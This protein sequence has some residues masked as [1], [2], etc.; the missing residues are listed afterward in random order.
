MKTRPHKI[1]LAALMLAIA[2]MASTIFPNIQSGAESPVI[3]GRGDYS[4]ENTSAVATS[5]VYEARR[6]MPLSFE[7]NRGQA[8]ADVKFVGRGDGFALLLKPNEAVLSL[9]KRKQALAGGAAAA[10]SND[11]LLASHLLSMKL[12]GANSTPLISGEEQQ[13]VR[14]NYFI[15][16]DPAKWLRDVETF[17]RVS[18]TGLYRGVDLTFY[19]N[20][21][22]LE[23]DFTVAPGADPREIRL[24]FEGADDVELNSEG[25]LILHTTAGAVRHDRPVAYQ[26][27]NGSRLE[28]PAE[29]RRL[30][31]GAIGF[32]V[33]SYDPARPLVIDPVLVY[34]TYL[35]GNAADSCRGIVVDSAGNSFLVGDSFSSN[36]LR[37]ASA[38]NSDVFIG[39]LSQSGLLL[40]YTFFG[41]SKNDSAT[42]LAVDSSGNLY[43]CG[44][45]E[46]PDFPIFNSVGSTLLG[47]SDAFVVKLTPPGDQ[48]FYSSLVGGSGSESGV[49]IAGDSAGNAYITGRTTSLDFPIV[50]PIQPVYGGGDSDAFVAKLAPDGKVL[51]YSSF[52]GGAGTEDLIAKT[53]IAVDS[54][55]NAYVVGDTQSSN[56]PTKNAIRATKTGDASALDGFV[57]KINPSGSDF[58]YSTY[59]GGSDDDFALA[60]AA[61][62]AGNAYAAGGTNSTT[63]TGSSS[64]RHSTGTRDAF[65]AKLNAA[66]SAI[67]YLTFVGGDN[68]EDRA[69]AIAIDSSGNA[70]IAGNAGEQFPAVN[71]IQSFFKGRE[72]ENDA[73]V[74][75]LGPTGVVTFSTYLGGSRDDVAL[76]VALDG[77]G[78]IYVAGFTD[79]TDFLTFAPLVRNNAG[80][81]DAFIAKIDPKADSNRPVLLQA[82]ISGKNLILYGQ[83][84]DAGAVLRINDETTKTRNDNPDPTQILFAK[85]A[86]KRIGEG[87]TVQLQIENPSGKR[88]NLLFLTKPCLPG[89]NCP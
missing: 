33:G 77:D 8:Q 56:F 9:Q 75:K 83:G 10:S 45:T 1:Q 16:N 36:F 14:A 82:L 35:G 37:N 38:T 42:G 19:G 63:F 89:F 67:S 52:L 74:T 76:A 71:S 24:R 20:Q 50:G 84:F 73:F 68:G 70:V 32:E 85:K 13:Q 31:D 66:G 41:G 27:R 43:L 46:S 61:D 78:A 62:Q 18:Y 39:K 81:R 55:G 7:T 23:Y 86:A 80:G 6:R 28:V 40:T 72:F 12:E 57:A 30:D 65:V 25:A 69:N 88:S 21:Q 17:S 5:A 15:G 4:E 54:S 64:T 34:S 59:L 22:Q 49:S 26:E 3:Q 29:F 48:F 58:V 87:Q 44:T 11:E 53:G 47:A 79:S 60:V 2:S 51:V